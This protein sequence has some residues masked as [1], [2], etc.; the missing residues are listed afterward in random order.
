[1]CRTLDAAVWDR[2]A[3]IL[4]DPQTIAREVEQLRDANTEADEESTTTKRIAEVE[5]RRSNLARS[6][7]ALDDAEASAPL[8]AELQTLS[9]RHKDL[10]SERDALAAQR[11]RRMQAQARMDSLAHW[12]ETVAS[13]LGNLDYEEKRMALEALSVTATVWRAD[14]QPRYAISLSVPLGDD[15]VDSF[16]R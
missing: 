11:L 1:V 14:H 6:L 3:T 13:N 15:I 10:L 9:N 7:A 8:L 5:R 12:C 16:S 2:I 4:R